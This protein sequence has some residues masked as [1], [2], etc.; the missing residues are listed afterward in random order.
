MAEKTLLAKI[1]IRHSVA[2]LW[3]DRNPTLR[4]GEFGLETDTF[5]IKIG[6]GVTD[7]AHLPYLNKLDETYFKYDT[8]GSLTFSDAFA[9]QIQNLIASGG[10]SGS[11][12]IENDPVEPTDPVNLRYLQ[13]AIAHAGHLKR[14]VVQ[15][16]PTQ[17]IDENTLYMMLAASGTY[18][19]EYMYINGAWD[20]VGS[21][22]DGAAGSGSGGGEYV[23]P[24]ATN[25]RL[26]GV[27]S[28]PLDNNGDILTDNDY[29]SVNENT[30]FMTLTQVSTSRLYVPQGDILV[31]YGG[32]A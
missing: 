4:E 27:K 13:W 12:V 11:F 14:A 19:E 5:L 6:D 16:L 10:G 1:Q 29:I 31:L 2:S 25:A 22:G 28:A 7:W 30:G 15:S 17:D 9:T 20:M 32:T 26:G 21:T 23:L 3:T 8:D 18:Y 24:V